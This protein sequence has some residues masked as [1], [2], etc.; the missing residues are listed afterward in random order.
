MMATIIWMDF[1][2]GGRV[3]DGDLLGEDGEEKIKSM[4]L[5]E[6]K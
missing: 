6:E 5:K 1:I 2:D 4:R 3:V